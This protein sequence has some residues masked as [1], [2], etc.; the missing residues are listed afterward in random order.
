VAIVKAAA[1]L[2]LKERGHFTFADPVL[3]LGVPDIY[4]TGRELGSIVPDAADQRSD[5][6]VSAPEFFRA[7]GLL[8]VTSLDIPGCAHEPDLVHD[9]NEPLPDGLRDRF[10][11]VVD[12]G[13]TEHVFDVRS[14]LTNIASALRVGGTVIHFV[15][16]YSY[17]GGYFSINPNVLHDFYALNGFDD[18]TAYIVMWDRYRPFAD[19]TLCYRYTSRLEARHA[20]ADRDQA[21]FTPHL[22]LF[23]RKTQSQMVYR[24][25]VQHDSH[26]V[27]P[28][29]GRASTARALARRLIPTETAIW[30]SAKLVRER[31]LRLSRRDSFS[32]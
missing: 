3:C 6:F 24:S 31:Q 1:R 11:I 23:A 4:L 8:Q 28:T 13:T 14:G 26:V 19:R 5:R 30:L 9:L 18:I 15:P 25:P 22:L 27:E 2:I 10:G 29:N 7:L 17:N 21:R 20:L 32:I 12:P 16:I